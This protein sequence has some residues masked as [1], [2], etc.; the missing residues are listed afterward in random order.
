MKSKAD[1]AAKKCRALFDDLVKLGVFSDTITDTDLYSHIGNSELP[2]VML[3]RD[4]K[5]PL[6]S[7]E[8]FANIP[9]RTVLK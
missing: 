6:Q 5:H 7:Q 3:P 9:S 2:F 1:A 8:T 4:Q